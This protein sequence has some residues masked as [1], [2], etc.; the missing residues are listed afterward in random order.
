MNRVLAAGGT[1]R[2]DSPRGGPTTLEVSVP[3]AS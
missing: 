3:C 2:L 1:T